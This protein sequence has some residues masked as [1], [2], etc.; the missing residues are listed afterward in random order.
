MLFTLYIHSLRV[1]LARMCN[2]SDHHCM[3][4]HHAKALS[5]SKSVANAVS[6][7]VPINGFC[8]MCKL[9]LKCSLG[10]LARLSTLS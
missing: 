4:P 9:R 2:I 10:S 6:K 8:I 5:C 3:R 7:P 1:L